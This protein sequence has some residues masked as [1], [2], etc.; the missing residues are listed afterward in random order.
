M[1]SSTILAK[2]SANLLSTPVESEIQYASLCIQQGEPQQALARYIVLLL[3]YQYGLSTIIKTSID[4][5]STPE[6]QYQGTIRCYF[7]IN[8][9]VPSTAIL[10]QFLDKQIPLI[11]LCPEA[12][13][14]ATKPNNSDNLSYCSWDQAFRPQQ[15]VLPQIIATIFAKY[16]IPKLYEAGFD[17]PAKINPKHIGHLINNVETLPTLPQIILHIMRLVHDPKSTTEQLEK[18]VLSDPAIVHK[19]LQVVNSPTFAGLAHTGQ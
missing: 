17:N 12:T 8:N 15:P 4:A 7:V 14:V 3:N 19:L 9:R 11:L 2:N 18:V 1:L 13:L 10:T 5:V 6:P 16:Q